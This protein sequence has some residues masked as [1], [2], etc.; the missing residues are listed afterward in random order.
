MASVG[1][2]EIMKRK[3]VHNRLALVGERFGRL[4]VV[5]HI[6]T[7][8][9]KS[10]WVCRCDCG[11]SVTVNGGSLTSGNTSSCGCL[12]LEKIKKRATRHGH[13]TVTAR[14]RTYRIW[15]AMLNRCRNP[16]QPNFKDYGGRGIT[17]CPRWLFFKAFLRDMGE[18]PEGFS[19]N[20][21]DNDGDYEPQNCRWASREEQMRNTR[22]NR[23]LT[24]NG[25]T[26]CLKDWAR[27][28]DIDQASLRERLEKWPVE[29]ALT[30]PRK[31][32]NE[33]PN[34]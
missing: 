14:T 13:A 3:S 26:K 30:Q 18:C 4:V 22:R 28:L 21:I 32:M 8:R 19:I 2:F 12:N 23:I 7:L 16:N 17:V 24:L 25:V 10:R 11:K 20:R 9:R 5:N 1:H 27:S 6:G 15:Q 31:P 34:I 29:R 33:R